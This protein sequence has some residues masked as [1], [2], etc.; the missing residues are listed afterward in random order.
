MQK[1]KEI[2]KIVRYIES[3][4]K[5]PV[6]YVDFRNPDDVF[7]KIPSVNIRL[8]KLD[9]TLFKRIER[10]PSIL[11]QVKEV[12]TKVK[13]LDLSWEKVNYLKLE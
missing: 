10:L 8:G 4:S 7:V 6:E 11:P 2:Q 3:Y 5:E 13:Y 1:I 9:N 12:K